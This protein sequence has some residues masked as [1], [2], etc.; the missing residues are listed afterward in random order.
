[1]TYFIH[2]ILSNMFRPAFWPS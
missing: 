2:S 1:M